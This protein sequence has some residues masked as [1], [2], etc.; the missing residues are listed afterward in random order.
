MCRMNEPRPDVDRPTGVSLSGKIRRRDSFLDHPL[1]IAGAVLF[2]IVLGV[3]V[4]YGSSTAVRERTRPVA[5]P[6]PAGIEVLV[7]GSDPAPEPSPGA[8]AEGGG[9]IETSK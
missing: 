3:A 8:T 4:M 7:D 2:G 1:Y 5:L 6:T 9:G